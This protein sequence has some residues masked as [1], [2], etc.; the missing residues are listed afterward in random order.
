MP[1]KGCGT[2]IRISAITD[3]VHEIQN[4]L[5]VNKLLVCFEAITRLCFEGDTDH[6]LLPK[7]T[8]GFDITIDV[9]ILTGVVRRE[10]P[11]R[12]KR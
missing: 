3:A 11:E 7:L 10:A 12:G 8:P 2:W 1:R 9:N 6:I 5:L 4:N